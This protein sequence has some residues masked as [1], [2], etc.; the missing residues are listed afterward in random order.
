[1]A[2]VIGGSPTALKKRLS[3]SLLGGIF[4]QGLCQE[5]GIRAGAEE[6]LQVS[7]KTVEN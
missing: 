4:E 5:A 2:R 3:S 1:V 6:L 7:V